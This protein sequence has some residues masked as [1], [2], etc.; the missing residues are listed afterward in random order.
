MTAL[1]PEELKACCASA[2]SGAAASFL[3]GDSF[4]P[5][6]AALTSRLARALREAQP[7]GGARLIQKVDGAVG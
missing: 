3:L 2:Y 1:A 4:H 5:G 7:Q 6:G